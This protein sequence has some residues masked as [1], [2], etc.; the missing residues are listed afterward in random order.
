MP[1]AGIW[2]IKKRKISISLTL[3]C[4]LSAFKAEGEREM[5][6]KNTE[7]EHDHTTFNQPIC[8]SF[9]LLKNYVYHLQRYPLDISA[10][11]QRILV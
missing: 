8:P 3:V 2:T 7:I 11:K 4:E 1:E 6:T 9:F 10:L 5:H